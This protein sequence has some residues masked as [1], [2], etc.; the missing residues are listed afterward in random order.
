MSPPVLR[1]PSGKF[2][3][4]VHRVGRRRRHDARAILVEIERRIVRIRGGSRKRRHPTG[5]T[6]SQGISRIERCERSR[7][8]VGS[9]VRLH[10]A[11]SDGLAI[12]PRIPVVVDI[13]GD[14]RLRLIDRDAMGRSRAPVRVVAVERVNPDGRMTSFSLAVP[15]SMIPI[16][17]GFQVL[18]PVKDAPTMVTG[19]APAE[20]PPARSSSVSEYKTTADS[21][22][23][24][25]VGCTNRRN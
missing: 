13:G 16:T 18:G 1:G 2:Y 4:G 15:W 24:E 7:Y 25:M 19:F 12:G 11:V 22:L 14:R 23:L 21:R 17:R 8:R 5:A 6:R 3:L 10:D 20:T 9:G